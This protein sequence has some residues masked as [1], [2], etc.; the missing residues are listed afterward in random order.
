M[1]VLS[2]QLKNLEVISL[3]ETRLVARL[4]AP[5]INPD[6]L[7]IKAFFCLAKNFQEQRIVLANDIA[8]INRVSLI[9]NSEEDVSMLSEV[10]RAKELVRQN[11]Q[12]KLLPVYS[13]S[14]VSLGKVED[15][16]IDL[17]S[18]KVQKIY[19]KQSLFKNLLLRRLII[20]RAQ[21]VEV[22]P[23]KIIV[24]DGSAKALARVT[25]PVA[26]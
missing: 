5:I 26:Q 4:G 19:V 18:F 10:V 22:T 12:L 17:G 16:T 8:K 3:R 15:Y 1:F 21:I 20:D 9:I 23:R 13:E 11:F 24:R 2:E 7:E 14:G 6:D 25:E